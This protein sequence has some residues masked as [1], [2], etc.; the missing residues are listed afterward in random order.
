MTQSQKVIFILSV[1]ILLV[2]SGSAGWCQVSPD[3]SMPPGSGAP[4]GQQWNMEQPQ[5]PDTSAAPSNQ[6]DAYSGTDTSTADTTRTAGTGN[7]ASAVRGPGTSTGSGLTGGLGGSGIDGLIAGSPS[8]KT[9]DIGLGFGTVLTGR[10]SQQIGATLRLSLDCTWGRF[11]GSK[12]YSGP[13]ITHIPTATTYITTGDGVESAFDV[14]LLSG[15][16]DL[17]IVPVVSPSTRSVELGPRFLFLDYHSEI[18]VG[19]NTTGSHL[20]GARRYQIPAFGGFFNLIR[21]SPETT[22]YF[23]FGGMPRPMVPSLRVAACF[24]G[25]ES[26]QCAQWEVFARAEIPGGWLRT[27]ILGFDLWI[28]S[29]YAEL[30]YIHYGLKEDV[31][32]LSAYAAGINRDQHVRGDSD[33]TMDSVI[34]RAGLEF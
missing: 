33:F 25:D 31:E 10:V 14:G 13:T 21:V 29:V 7:E 16:V 6:Y 18:N 27:S 1:V 9:D 24:G 22:Y 15:I 20:K 8:F 30:G 11:R 26:V 12:K 5:F 23:L 4:P 3:S 17:D 2:W 19:N 28:S 34:A 32:T